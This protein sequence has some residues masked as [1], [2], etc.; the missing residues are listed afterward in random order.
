MFT[1][2]RLQ[3]FLSFKQPTEVP[4]RK[5]SVLLGPNNVGKSNLLRALRFVSGLSSVSFADRALAIGMRPEALVFRDDGSSVCQVGLEADAPGAQFRWAKAVYGLHLRVAPGSVPTAQEERI[6]V[7]GR[8][9]AGAIL[10]PPRQEAFVKGEECRVQGAMSLFRASGGRS[11]FSVVDN[12]EFLTSFRDYLGALRYFHLSPAA[13]RSPAPLT[14][15]PVLESDGR[16]LPAVLDHL[17]DQHQEEYEA[18]LDQ[19][20]SCAP[21]VERIQ[22]RVMPNGQ[23]VVMLKERGFK[24]SFAAEEVSEGLLLLLALLC[25]I[26]SPPAPSV[27]CLEE[28]EHGVHP[29][30]L[31]DIVGFLYRLAEGEKGSP[32]PQIVLTSHSPYFLDLFKDDLEAV[33]VLDR[34]E[35]G[36]KVSRA[37]E[38]LNRIGGLRGS[39]LGEVWYSGVLGGVPG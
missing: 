36:T 10:P 19:F 13:L 8:T 1:K 26:H 12:H 29:R 4:L 35:H 30:R 16:G 33:L 32:G 20:R 22:L 18:L 6:S 3:S 25:A 39:P 24:E 7:E 14:P 5:L 27:I 28:P 11:I 23:K 37:S 21:E 31:K 38:V 15:E 9:A 17:K 2:L 34:D